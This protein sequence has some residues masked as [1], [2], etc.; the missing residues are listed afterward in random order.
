MGPQDFPAAG[1]QDEQEEPPA[2]RD[3]T[4]LDFLAPQT[5]HVWGFV[6]FAK[7]S[8]SSKRSPHDLHSY[9]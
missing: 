1:E 7:D 5:G 6:R 3:G 2:M 8:S 9:S 4:S